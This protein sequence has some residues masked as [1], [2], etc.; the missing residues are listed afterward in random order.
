MMAVV[1]RTV[2]VV[3]A[4]HRPD[5]GFLRQQIR[6]ILVQEFHSVTLIV[7]I[8]GSDPEAEAEVQSLGD[9]RIVALHSS[10]HIGILHAFE[11]G[12][13]RAVRESRSAN[14]LFAFADQDD[15]WGAHKLARLASEI[16]RRQCAMAFSDA[17]V[18]DSRNAIV[19]GSV[20]ESENRL[21]KPTLGNLIVSNCVS[22][23]SMLFDK[24]LAQLSLPFPAIGE[25]PVLHDWWIA[26]LGRS[27]GAISFVGEPLVH[28]RLHQANIIGPR[29]DGAAGPGPGLG[30]RTGF[31]RRAVKHFRI[32]QALAKNA[33]V[34]L[35]RAG[36]PA[37]KLLDTIANGGI[38]AFLY[39]SCQAAL[40]LLLWKPQM[41]SIA[42]GAAIGS[43]CVR[44][45]KA[46]FG[47]PPAVNPE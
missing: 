44:L 43:A 31:V 33:S 4:I 13:E 25:G 18:I 3:M 17:A 7:V 32:R 42:S 36:L 16:D 28:Y 46:E 14:D 27:L 19:S 37:P 47:K 6:S 12:L 26:V 21:K 34:T 45:R 8:D 39:F 22:G 30:E 1:R 5:I 38:G 35:I 10:S 9:S 2:F 23:M 24:R 29:V 11:L 20:F 41:S 15:I 40:L